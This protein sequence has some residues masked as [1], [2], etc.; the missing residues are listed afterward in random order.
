MNFDEAIRVHSAWKTRL[1]SYLRRPDGSLHGAEV[2][3]DTQ[4]DLGKWLGSA[5]AEMSGQPAFK[6]LKTS[7]AAFHSAA[8]ALVD[9]A[10]SGRPTSELAAL[11]ASSPFAEAS[12]QVVHA[13]MAMKRRQAA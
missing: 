8:G 10:N 5:A 3:T 9:I 4:C 1:A 13:L 7:H 6:R 11:G 2:C 12:R